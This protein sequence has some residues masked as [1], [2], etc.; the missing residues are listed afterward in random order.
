MIPIVT[1]RPMHKDEARVNARWNDVL[2]DELKKE[3]VTIRVQFGWSRAR[4]LSSIVNITIVEN[5]DST[6]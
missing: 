6:K 3:K 1:Y 2:M 4:F 5:D